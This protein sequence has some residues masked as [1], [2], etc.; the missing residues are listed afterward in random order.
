MANPG[1]RDLE[2]VQ[3]AGADIAVNHAERGQRQEP[4]AAR[5]M[6]VVGLVGDGAGLMETK[7][8]D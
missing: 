3:R 1:E 8:L 4:R 5:M 6:Q 7:T 2:R